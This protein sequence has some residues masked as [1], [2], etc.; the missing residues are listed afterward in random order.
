METY[1]IIMVPAPV[2]R[3]IAQPVENVDDALRK[4]M[5]VM[6]DNKLPDHE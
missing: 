5:D 4:Q 2:L 3:E 6:L 1:D